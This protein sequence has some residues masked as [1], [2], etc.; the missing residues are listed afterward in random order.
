[1]ILDILWE[2]FP[3]ID[4]FFK[5]G[6]GYVPTDNDRTIQRKA[7]G[8]RIFGKLREDFI[9]RPVE[10]DI[11]SPSFTHFSYS[12]GIRRVGLSSSFSIQIP[13]RLIFA[14]MLRRSEQDTP[15]PYGTGSTV[16]RQCE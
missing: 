7:G 15:H 1:M 9:H 14:L 8:D 10:V 12:S 13:S 2:P 6:M 11:H 5:L 4:A 16:A 3:A